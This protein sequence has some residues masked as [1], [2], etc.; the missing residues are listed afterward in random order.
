MNPKYHTRFPRNLDEAGWSRQG[1]WQELEEPPHWLA[2]ILLAML[3]AG[4]LGL[5]LVLVLG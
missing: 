1:K 2:I 4:L 3:G 5:F